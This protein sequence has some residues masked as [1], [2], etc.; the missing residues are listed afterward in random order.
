MKLY[1]FFILFVLIFPVSA[2]TIDIYYPNTNI[3]TEIFYADSNG[4][5][6]I[7]SNTI[8]GNFN[9]VILNDDLEYDNIIESPHKIISPMFK[10]IIIIILGSLLIGIVIIFKRLII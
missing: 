6:K 2:T 3:S 5:D 1:Y 7:I 10:L 9:T 4:W 8:S